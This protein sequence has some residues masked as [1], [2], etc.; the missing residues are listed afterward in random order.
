M[1]THELWFVVK[2]NSSHTSDSTQIFFWGGADLWLITVFL[3]LHSKSLADECTCCCHHHHHYWSHSESQQ[4]WLPFQEPIISSAHAQLIGQN[5]LRSR[6]QLWEGKLT[7]CLWGCADLSWVAAQKDSRLGIRDWRLGLGTLS[8]RL[9][10]ILS[11]SGILQEDGRGPVE[12]R[13]WAPSW[14]QM[15]PKS[16]N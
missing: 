9:A 7:H 1:G 2:F 15:P 13:R 3:S 14:L 11:I 10:K 12:L 5:I 4:A 16:Q 8:W 6:G